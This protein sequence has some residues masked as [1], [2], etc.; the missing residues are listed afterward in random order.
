M[1]ANL[2]ADNRKM[3]SAS[4]AFPFTS[5]YANQQ[6]NQEEKRR[7]IFHDIVDVNDC[8]IKT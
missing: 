1:A 6:E 7:Q 3:K 2:A 5:Q 8:Q 4:N